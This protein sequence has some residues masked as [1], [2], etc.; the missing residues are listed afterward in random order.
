MGKHVLGWN[1]QLS[2][3][4]CGFLGLETYA[5]KKTRSPEINSFPACFL[6]APSCTVLKAFRRKMLCSGNSGTV[7]LDFLS[8]L[9]KSQMVKDSV[10]LEIYSAESQKPCECRNGKM[11]TT[12]FRILRHCP[13]SQDREPKPGAQRVT[14]ER[15]VCQLEGQ[16]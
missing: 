7:S 3:S 6:H 5:W 15:F 13:V 4:H 9:I 12:K 8:E 11:I 10:N 14:E 2:G 16:G 1:D